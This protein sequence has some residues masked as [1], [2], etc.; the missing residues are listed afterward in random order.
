MEPFLEEPFIING[1]KSCVQCIRIYNPVTE[2]GYAFNYHYHKYIE[3]LYGI[4]CGATVWVDGEPHCFNSGDLMIIRA[5]A[6]HDLTFN[7]PSKYICIKFSSSI[8]HSNEDSIFDFKYIIPLIQGDT[9]IHILRNNIIK[10]SGIGSLVSEAMDEWERHDCAYEMVVRSN[11]LKIF[12]W[13]FRYWNKCGILTHENNISEDIK[14]AISYISENYT[15][16]NEK[17]VAD[18]CGLS[19]NYFSSAFKIA[20]GRNF[21]E[22]L[23][24]LRLQA[25]K[26]QLLSSQKSI[27]E[28]ALMVGFSTA[29]HFISC[30]KKHIGLTPKRFRSRA[31]AHKQ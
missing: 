11:I 24:Q 22:Y 30:F 15:A 26:K 3:F 20:T 12:S 25:S 2:P 5:N 8:L 28:I 17:D 29:S 1:M 10:C 13:I 6:A 18:A 14:K 19:Y 16:V 7:K 4:D 31:L 27:T 23:I 9:N 21:N